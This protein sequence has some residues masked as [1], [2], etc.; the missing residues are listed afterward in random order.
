[1]KVINQDRNFFIKDHDEMIKFVGGFDGQ[2]NEK[3]YK[4]WLKN[5][6]IKKHSNLICKIK[7]FINSN[8]YTSTVYQ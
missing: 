7:K 4:Y 6:N 3:L 8:K 5:F 2:F 1:M